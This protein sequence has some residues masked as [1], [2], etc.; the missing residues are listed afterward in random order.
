MN[1]RLVSARVKPKLFAAFILCLAIAT[2]AAADSIFVGGTAGISFGVSGYGPPVPG[3]P[4]YIPNNFTGLVDILSS[5]G[6]TFFTANPVIANNISSGAGFLPFGGF[7][8]GGGNINGPFG[9]GIVAI[10]GPQVGFFLSDPIPGGGSASYAVGSWFANFVN[11]VAYAGPFGTFLAMG[12]ILPAIGSADV[13]ALRTRITSLDPASPFFG[14]VDLPQL[15]LANSRNGPLLYSA[16][17]LGGSGAAIV[18]DNAVAG[19]FW[20]LA[21]NNFPIVIPAGDAFTAVSTLTIYADPADMFSFD[22]ENPPLELDA[23][24]L[25][26]LFQNTGPLPAFSLIGSNAVPEPSS[27]LLFGMGVCGIVGYVRRRR[28]AA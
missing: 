21:V 1:N 26:E 2:P 10:T 7:Q 8:V 24:V 13:A 15:V 12:G 16:V 19:T 9:A 22:P 27:L 5:P 25:A 11:P 17:A 18:V 20:G 3:V 4:T 28:S 23:A 14:G 6:G